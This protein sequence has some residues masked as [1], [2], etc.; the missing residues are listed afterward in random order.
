MAVASEAMVPIAMAALMAGEAVVAAAGAVEAVAAVVAVVAAAAVA[1][2]AAAAAAAAAV[3]P[4]TICLR[5]GRTFQH[6]IAPASC[7]RRPRSARGRAL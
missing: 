6:P 5:T 2:V 7:T 3:A 1:A 4:A